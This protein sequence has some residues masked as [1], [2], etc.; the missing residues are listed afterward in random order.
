MGG[1]RLKQA[2]RLATPAVIATVVCAALS[3]AR[4][5]DWRITPSLSAQETYTDNVFLAPDKPPAATT[6]RTAAERQKESDLITQ[7]VPGVAVV[8][9]GGRASVFAD[10][11]LDKKFFRDH[12]ERDSLNHRFTTA[13]NVEVWDKQAFIDARASMSRQTVSALEPTSQ[14]AAGQEVN[15]VDVLNTD[16]TPYFLH[17]FGTWLE[18]RSELGYRTFSTHN[19]SEDVTRAADGVSGAGTT[20]TQTVNDTQTYHAAF[21]ANTGRRFTHTRVSLRD[22]RDKLIRSGGAPHAKTERTNIDLTQ[23]I[24]PEW[25]LLAGIGKEKIED[26][27][28]IENRDAITWNAGAAWQPG[29][30][31][32]VRATYGETAIGETYD[33]NLSHRFSEFTTLNVVYTEAIQNEQNQQATTLSFLGTDANGNLIDTRTGAPFGQDSD[34]FGLQNIAFIQR[35]FQ[36]TL[37]GSRGRTVFSASAVRET[38]EYEAINVLATTLEGRAD[39][40]RRLSSRSSVS[41]GV[42][43]QDQDFGDSIDRTDTR[44]SL[45]ASWSYQ[46][47]PHLSSSLSYRRTQRESTVETSNMTE[48]AVTLGLVQTF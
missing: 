20:G 24:S 27:T 36:A 43:Y 30:R 18:T 4:G 23:I 32:N 46:I 28:L 40:S 3:G 16:I 9:R 42:S 35:R 38:R 48:N 41:A 25:S 5:A 47:G 44:L 39:L 33:F 12:S 8:G 37:S 1:S 34:S 7:I 15:Q 13:G 6:T 21:M 29:R 31:T 10:Y 22:V 11:S 2:T 17:H 45:N 14:S 19:P 26:E